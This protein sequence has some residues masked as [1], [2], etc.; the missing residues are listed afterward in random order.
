MK[1]AIVTGGAGFI[2]SNLVDQL[3]EEDYEVTCID[4]ASAENNERFYWNKKATNL[5]LD[6]C[7]YDSLLGAFKQ[8]GSSVV[9]HLA[10]EARIQPSIKDP[11][12]TC[13]TNVIGTC[14]VLQASREAGIQR[15][16]Y[17]STSSAYGSNNTPP[18]RET[19]P[20]DCK[21]PYSISKV[22][23]EDLCRAYFELYGLE[24][25]TFRY[26]NVYGDRQPL[27]GEYAPV[28]GLFMRQRKDGEPMTVIGNG[29]QTRDFTHVDDVVQANIVASNP[30]LSE[31]A[32]GEVFNIGTGQSYS[33]IELAQRIGGEV[34]FLP[35]RLGES[36]ASLA[37]ISK[38]KR[39]LG[40]TPSKSLKEYLSNVDFR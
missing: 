13:Q 3:L 38:A 15:V 27:K 40:W 32:F 22:A 14:N 37:D 2:G 33:I 39:L 20:R 1:K 6:I 4:N 36:D 31:T 7:E 35:E 28:I 12:K 18:Y 21:T 24:T 25:V 34:C 9:F 8:A 26:F 10:A 5:H 11:R 29:S 16:I 30:A 17:S 23:G 19:D